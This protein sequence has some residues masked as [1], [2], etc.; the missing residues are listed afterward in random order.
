MKHFYLSILVLF[1]LGSSRAQ[2]LW[3]ISGNGLQTKSYLYGTI[4]VMPKEKFSISPKIQNAFQNTTALALEVKLKMSLIKQI[5][6]A[7]K[8]FLPKGKTLK[9]YLSENEFLRLKTYCID[10]IKLTETKFNKYIHLKPFFF[11]SLISQEQMGEISSYEIE[12]DK[13]AKSRR[14]RR[15]G[16]ESIEYQLE[17]I[18]KMSIEDQ[19]K[20][21]MD[22]IDVNPSTQFNNLL[23]L[24]LNEDLNGLY[25]AVTAESNEIPDFN[26]N[27]L[28]KRN[29]NWIPIIEKQISKKATFIAVGAAHLPGENGVIQLLK[30]KGYQVIPVN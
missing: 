6:I 26:Q 1:L 19:V 12:L 18:N 10:S 23:T 17:T 8:S 9:N 28:V 25:E 15:M 24:Y 21:M 13:M 20:M 11:S 27:F 30:S 3:E 5:K 4:H 22:E 2:L 16:L 29:T 7:K 14:K